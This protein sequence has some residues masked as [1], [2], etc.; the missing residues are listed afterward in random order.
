MTL[1]R[2]VNSLAVEL[3][4][5]SILSTK[6]KRY[7][8]PL[9]AIFIVALIL[10]VSFIILFSDILTPPTI[11]D[12]QPNIPEINSPYTTPELLWQINAPSN[13]ADQ[14]IVSN[15]A[16]CAFH[17]GGVYGSIVSAVNATDG[18]IVWKKSGIFSSEDVV[19]SSVSVDKMFYIQTSFGGLF[20]LS[21]ANGDI[22]WASEECRY[23]GSSYPVVAVNGI[24]Y[25]SASGSLIA[26]NAKDGTKLWN[27]TIGGDV[28][29]PSSPAVANGVVYIGSADNHKVYALDAE[30]G[31]L[32][33]E[34]TTGGAVTSSPTVA[35][36]IVYIGSDDNKLYALN[37]TT[38]KKIWSY[39]TGGGV[40][41]PAVEYGVVYVG[42]RDQN[43]YA[44]NAQ[45]GKKIWN[46]NTHNDVIY[47]PAVANGVVYTTVG[48][49]QQ[50]ALYALNAATGTKLWSHTGAYGP[51][52][53]TN[54]VIYVSNRTSIYA[55][56]TIKPL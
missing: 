43:L 13:S 5:S 12:T 22:L 25:A 17:Y 15:G 23:S 19:S 35:N 7:W 47:R 27:Y 52:I 33:W 16:I 14:L 55:F 49:G 36:G 4:K 18:T 11:S 48:Y 3:P 20:A 6:H 32:F 41:S 9:L 29:M 26:L 56:S 24:V 31:D 54:N 38:G 10:A 2:K 39:K 1:R 42:S 46:Y 8:I 34:Y 44:L 50:P 21:T 51:P 53:I 30:K 28:Y 37:A 40:G 45:T